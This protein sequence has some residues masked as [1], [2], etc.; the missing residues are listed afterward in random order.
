V[1]DAESV[2]QIQQAI[3][4]VD[5]APV[6]AD[7]VSLV[8]KLRQAGVTVSDRRAVRLQRVVAGSALLAGRTIARTS[9]LWIFAHVWDREEQIEIIAMLVREVL[10]EAG[11]ASGDHPRAYAA[12]APD[13]EALAMALTELANRMVHPAGPAAADELRRL[14]ARIGWV[15]NSESRRA[16]QEQEAALWQQVSPPP[17]YPL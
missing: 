6:R 2:R 16:L 5:L 14:G 7:F 1:L 4:F 3:R 15:R 17:A 13:P 10:D 8:L 12:E 11:P 9:D